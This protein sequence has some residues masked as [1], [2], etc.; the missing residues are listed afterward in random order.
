MGILQDLRSSSRLGLLVA[1]SAATVGIIYGY[2]SSNIGGAL[3]FIT[4]EFNLSVGQQQLVTTAVVVGEVLGALFGGALANR[5]G[6]KRSMVLV[7]G[8]F[9][10]FS[11][12]SALAWSVPSL[13]VRDTTGT[14]RRMTMCTGVAASVEMPASIWCAHSVYVLRS[15]LESAGTRGRV[16]FT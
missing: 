15:R 4:K 8:T 9:A 10:L 7:A 12:M 13:I 14:S 16:R 6:R 11:L 5:I 2:D 1:V 3:L